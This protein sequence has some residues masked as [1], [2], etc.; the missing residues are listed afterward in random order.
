MAQKGWTAS[1]E[2]ESDPNFAY[3]CLKQP[4]NKGPGSCSISSSKVW[5]VILEI[6]FVRVYILK[7]SL[8]VYIFSLS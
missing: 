8:A 5:Q 1:K 4:E 3:F 7:S 6:V 2:D